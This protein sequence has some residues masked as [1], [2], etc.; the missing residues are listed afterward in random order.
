[1]DLE[2]LEQELREIAKTTEPL[3]KREKEIKA[4]IKKNATNEYTTTY[5]GIQIQIIPAFYTLEFDLDKFRVEHADLFEQYLKPSLHPQTTK[6]V[7]CKV[8]G[9]K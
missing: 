9:E 8:K 7:L 5:G 4:E 2:K 1:M 6:I 3:L